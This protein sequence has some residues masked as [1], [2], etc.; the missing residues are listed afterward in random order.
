MKTPTKSD[1]ACGFV[2]V[3]AMLGSSGMAA[4]KAVVQ[5]TGI[6]LLDGIV[7]A[8]AGVG[9]CL[10]LLLLWAGISVVGDSIRAARRRR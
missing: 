8:M 4:Y 2:A 6:C 5:G 9:L 7:L 3:L 1:H 10:G